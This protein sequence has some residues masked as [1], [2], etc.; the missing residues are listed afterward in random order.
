MAE[1]TFTCWSC[2]ET[3]EMDDKVTRSDECPHCRNDMRSCKNCQYYDSGSHN[4]CTETISE[5]VTTKER[6]TFCGMYRHIQGEREALEDVDE[7]KR[8][9]EALFG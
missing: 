1:W 5:Y 8:K 2:R 9:L 7:A 4:E 6:N 3:T